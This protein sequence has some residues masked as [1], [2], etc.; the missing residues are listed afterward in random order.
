MSFSGGLSLKVGDGGDPEIFTQVPN[1]FNMSPVGSTKPL[2][3]ITGWDSKS[4]Q[5]ENG[6]PDGNDFSVEMIREL[7][8]PVQDGLVNDVD[9]DV[10]RNFKLSMDNGTR[11]ETFDLS[12]VLN[13]WNINPSN[14]DRHT[15]I[16]TGKIS[17]ATT[18]ATT[19]TSSGSG[20]ASFQEHILLLNPAHYWKLDELSGTVAVDLGSRGDSLTYGKDSSTA[21]YSVSPSSVH[22]GLN[23]Q[24]KRFL[25]QDVDL[26]L[27]AVEGLPGKLVSTDCSFEFALNVGVIGLNH[28]LFL[29]SGNNGATETQYRFQ[30][31]DSPNV[32]NA[33]FE[34]EN[35]ES[36]I[37]NIIPNLDS[38]LDSWVYVSIVIDRTTNL[39]TCRVDNVE[40]SSIDVSGWSANF[41][42]SQQFGLGRFFVGRGASAIST[43]PEDLSIDEIQIYD[44]SL[45]DEQRTQN[46]NYWSTGSAS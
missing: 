45:T 4:E 10:T 35:A 13:S 18:R 29:Y 33:T 30:V 44:Y 16:I 26:G 20:A 21:G 25:N 40:V 7:D 19:D 6:F 34:I 2:Q 5:Y 42:D 9:N 11:V 28:P 24:A 31:Q 15:L 12:V 3:K 37:E 43:T 32:I 38:Y 8:N 39:L 36:Y 23:S 41:A 14:D 17:D 46:Y 22:T 1:I 27:S